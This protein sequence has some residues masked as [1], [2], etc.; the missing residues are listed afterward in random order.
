MS[1]DKLSS[2]IETLTPNEIDVGAVPKLTAD[3]NQIPDEDSPEETTGTTTQ[4]G[5]ITDDAGTPFNPNIHWEKDG[6]I[7][8]KKD[9]TFKRKPGNK[10]GTNGKENVSYTEPNK[11]RNSITGEES[12]TFSPDVMASMF[13]TGY[14]A[15]MSMVV[16]DEFATPIKQTFVDEETGKTF[17]WD[18]AQMMRQAFKGTIV[19]RGIKAASPE[20]MILLTAMMG[21][22]AR[23]MVPESKTRAKILKPFATGFQKFKA[24]FKSVFKRKKK[25]ET[26]EKD[27]E[28]DD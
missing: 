6:E 22:C 19:K 15:T 5:T 28:K 2:D 27:V 21:I 16:S 9:G 10:R 17:T 18:E 1:S 20:V 4:P 3:F 12:I 23:A 24:G 7:Q 8:Y 26:T 11:T 25:P 14:F 13:T